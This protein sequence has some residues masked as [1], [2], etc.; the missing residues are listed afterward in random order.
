MKKKVNSHSDQTPTM[1]HTAL[2]SPHG[3]LRERQDLYALA[4]LVSLPF[5]FSR[6]SPQ[7][8]PAQTT[9]PLSPLVSAQPST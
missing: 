5:T 1:Y 8:R 6:P 3:R 9:P 2:G 4:D 7:H